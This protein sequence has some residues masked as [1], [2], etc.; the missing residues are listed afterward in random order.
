MLLSTLALFNRVRLPDLFWNWPGFARF[1][2]GPWGRGAL[3]GL[4]MAMLFGA[5]LEAWELVDH[6][7]IRILHRHDVEH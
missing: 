7:L 3:L 6:L 2:T 5:L 4:A 1:L